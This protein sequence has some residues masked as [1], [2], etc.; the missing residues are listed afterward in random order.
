M[1]DDDNGDLTEEDKNKQIEDIRNGIPYLIRRFGENSSEV[2]KAKAD[3]ASLERALREAKPYKTHRAQLERRKERLERQH[4]KGK[5]EAE[6]LLIDI[7]R[8]Q[9]RL[10]TTNKANDER[11]R[12]IAVVDEELREL[13]KRAIA[14]G[15]GEPQQQQDQVSTRQDPTEAWNTVTATLA[16]MVSQPG[17]PEAWAAQMGSLLDQIRIAAA[18][19]QRQTAATAAL[20]TAGGGGVAVASNAN[21][22]PT[23]G[24]PVAPAV[25]GASSSHNQSRSAEGGDGGAAGAAAAAA[26]APAAPAAAAAA[27][28]ASSSSATA[29]V[30]AAAEAAASVAAGGGNEGAQTGGVGAAAGSAATTP[31]GNATGNQG[32]PGEVISDIE[33][34]DDMESIQGGDFD[35]RSGESEQERKKRIKFQLREREKK[36]QEA[37]RRTGLASKKGA[38]AVSGTAAK[39]GAKGQNVAPRDKK[40]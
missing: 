18:T 3:S 9:A 5:E 15:E 34:D 25:A 6:Q 17:V 26:A 27:S 33:S 4:E 21:A 1:D 12:A 32:A 7:E 11:E 13:L 8:L 20:A 22:A 36:R 19:I 37:R 10:N 29:A 16:G 2:E 35:L 14:E 30:T 24:A 31:P 28:S 40:K 38:S 23:P 39:D